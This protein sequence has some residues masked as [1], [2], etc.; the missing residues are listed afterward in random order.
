MYETKKLN[1][2]EHI[3]S[4]LDIIDCL[5]DEKYENIIDIEFVNDFHRLYIKDESEIKLINK[6]TFMNPFGFTCDNHKSTFELYIS[7]EYAYKI[8]KN[9]IN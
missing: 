6:I 4:T 7:K 2:S 8:L 1:K 5:I 9:I 3:I